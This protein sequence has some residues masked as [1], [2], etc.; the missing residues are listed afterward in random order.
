M[1]P[2][3]CLC[4]LPPYIC[5][6]ESYTQMIKLNSLVNKRWINIPWSCTNAVLTHF[7][8]GLHHENISCCLPFGSSIMPVTVHSVASGQSRKETDTGTILSKSVL[9]LNVSKKDLNWKWADVD[10]FS[11]NSLKIFIWIGGN[12]SL[13][14]PY[15]IMV[16]IWLLNFLF[17]EILEASCQS[18]LENNWVG[19]T[20][21][22][23]NNS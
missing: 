10:Y 8:L 6:P 4:T 19:S 11:T 21:P 17:S 2:Q 15:K 13:A 16:L 7:I 23:N 1:P 22:S 14:P 12:C 18:L 20:E 3:I 9:A 5:A